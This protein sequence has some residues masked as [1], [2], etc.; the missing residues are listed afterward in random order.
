MEANAQLPGQTSELGR[1][2]EASLPFMANI[3]SVTLLIDSTTILSLQKHVN[4]NPVKVPVHNKFKPSDETMFKMIVERVEQQAVRVHVKA[5]PS[6]YDQVTPSKPDYDQ[7]VTLWTAS[8]RAIPTKASKSALKKITKKSVPELSKIRIAIV[9]KFLE[10]TS[11][12][13]ARLFTRMAAT[14]TIPILL[15]HPGKHPKR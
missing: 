4:P 14:I 11:F 12:W 13:I 15:V 7:D 1:F 8:I 3:T 2:L 6:L 5:Q 9:S 10:R